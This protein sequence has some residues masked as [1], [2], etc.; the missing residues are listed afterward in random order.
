MSRAIVVTAALA[1]LIGAAPAA[2][3]APPSPVVEACDPSGYE[4]DCV[5]DDTTFDSD[6][7]E[8]YGYGA[9]VCFTLRASRAGTFWRVHYNRQHVCVSGGQVTDFGSAQVWAENNLFAPLSWVYGLDFDT[10]Y[11][12]TDPGI[13]TGYASSSMGYRVRFC[14]WVK[15]G[16]SVYGFITLD[17][18][19]WGGVYCY[20][21]RGPIY[22]CRGRI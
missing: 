22:G 19:G 11:G 9:S 6:L 5:M 20:S 2:A 8:W 10:T 17:V 16:S 3:V 4:P 12:P 13:P 1:A 18:A 15:C 14:S 21:D 7:D